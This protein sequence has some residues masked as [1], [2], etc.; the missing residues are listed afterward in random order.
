MGRKARAWAEEA[1]DIAAIGNHFRTMLA[2]AAEARIIE[3]PSPG[4]KLNVKNI[5]VAP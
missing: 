2:G 3:R 4:R 1:F 5:E